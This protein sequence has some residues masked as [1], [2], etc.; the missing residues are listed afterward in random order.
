VQYGPFGRIVGLVEGVSATLNYMDPSSQRNRLYVAPGGH[1]RTAWYTPRTVR[2]RDGRPFRDDFG[3]DRSGFA[4]LDHDSAV[5]DFSDPGELDGRYTGEATGLVREVTG[6]DEVV[7]LGWVIRR[8]GEDK[9]GAQPPAPDVHV[10]VH[11]GRAHDR[12]IAAASKGRPFR[13]AIMTSLWRAFSPPPQ[14]WPLA[15]LDYRSVTDTEGVPNLLLFVD[16]LPDLDDVPG[17]PDP[18]DVPGI[19]DPDDFPAGAVFIWRPEHR[20]WYFPGMHAGETLLFK[21]H[22]TD[23]SVA[24]RAPHTAFYDAGASGAHPRESVELRTVAFFY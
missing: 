17:I 8:A 6:A 13:R 21:L 1:V 20:W 11:P 23:H 22:D 18:D 15:I 7:P 14:D 12:M 10:D 3:L 4:L 24:W 9:R 19:P 16:T 2:I 5:T